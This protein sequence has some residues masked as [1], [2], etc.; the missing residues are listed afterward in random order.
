MIPRK[1]G[2]YGTG[3]KPVSGKSPGQ[4]IGPKI[5]LVVGERPKLVNK[6][7]SL[8]IPPS[9]NPSGPGDRPKLAQ[10][11]QGAQGLVRPSKRRQPSTSEHIKPTKSSGNL[12]KHPQHVSRPPRQTPPT[13]LLES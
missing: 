10:D 11:K 4:R 2:D 9:S 7:H 12:T 5:K 8:L 1:K 13:N 3:P 6:P